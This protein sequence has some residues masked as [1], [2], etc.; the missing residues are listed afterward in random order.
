MDITIKDIKK[1]DKN[2]RGITHKNNL[3]YSQTF[4]DIS[5][6]NIY[7]KTENLQKTGSFKI[8]GAYNKIVN[9]SPQEKQKGVIASSAG[10]HAQ[11]VALAAATYGIKSTIVMPSA[12]PLAK[13]SATSSYGA[14]VV[15]HGTVYD[16]CYEK[17][18]EIQAQTG[19]VFV[20]PFD[21]ADVIAGQGT[22]GLE[23]LEELPDIDIII[24]PIGGGGII[25]GIAIAAKALKPDVKIIGVQSKSADSMYQ[26][27]KEG[28]ITSLTHTNSIADGIAVKKPGKL[29][30]E[31]CKQYVDEVILIEEDEIA[32]SV[33]MLL[34]RCK[35]LAEGAGAAAV[36]PLISGRLD[37]KNKNIVSVITGGNIDV[38]I[39]ARIIDKGLV[40]AGRKFELKIIM[41]D[42][43]G[44]LR[45]LLDTIASV[46][47]NIVS[48][49]QNRIK[50]Y[51][52]VGFVEVEIVIETLN[53]DHV[54]EIII[55]LKNARYK[56]EY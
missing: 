21:D 55:T 13:V 51:I 18:L 34:E 42:R 5:G 44:Q 36:A 4:S 25:S 39:L 32:N 33:L 15:L 24:V 10:N 1:A 35:L 3:I 20:H 48:I 27:L 47:G 38:T 52:A 19:A 12:A 8:R 50:E 40:K 22:I 2:L 37:C 54:E 53:K 23:I 31:I 11:G 16:D 43:P 28:K 45:K 17:A 46:S 41:E 49:Q 30:Y 7:L 29:T 26:S 56:I 14:E 9:L 6:N